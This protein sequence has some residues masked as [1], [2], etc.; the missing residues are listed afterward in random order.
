MVDSKSLAVKTAGAGV[1]T[2]GTKLAS[3]L[4]DLGILLCLARFLGP[5]EF[6][7]V[8]VAMAVVVV[9]EALFELP[10]AA[11]L[12]RVQFLTQPMLHTAFTLSVLR[13]ILIA[14]LLILLSLPLSLFTSEPRLALLVSVLAL[15][16]MARGLVSPRMVEF[17]RVFNFRPDAMLEIFG[18]VTAFVVSVAVAVLT[19]SYWAIAAATICGPLASTALSY[20]MAPLKPKLTLSQWGLFSNIIGWNFFSQLGSAL[21]WQIDRLLLPR[22][23]TVTAFGHYAMGKQ[24]SEIPVQALI[25]PLVRPTMAALSVAGEQRGSRYLQLS[26]GIALVMVPVMGIPIMWPDVII[27]LALGPAWLPAAQ[28]LRWISVVSMLVLP[29]LLMAS[30]TMTLDRTRWLAVKTSIELA[31]R[32]PLVWLGASLIGIGGAIAGSAFATL[33]GTAAG[34]IIVKHLAHIGIGAQLKVLWTPM[35]AILPAAAI[36]HFCR[37][38]VISAQGLSEHL[39][40]TVIPLLGYVI[41]YALLIY[42]T[43]V[44]GRRPPGVE[45]HLVEIMARR[46]RQN[47]DLKKT[48][49]AVEDGFN[50]S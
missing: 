48:L 28:W 25:Q 39:V 6:G 21:N 27:R 16:P 4:I 18:K 42:A 3:K 30:L 13:G 5:A 45:R 41:V 8:A 33:I 14:V 46:F 50:H 10:I 36:L 9:V 17:A 43:W 31:V 1:W 47:S 15:A 7:L 34:L 40:L 26:H 12:I 19:R 22:L 20:I 38:M 37:P 49:D 24:I 44:A 35:A 23:T 29:A 32:L 11:A 2:I